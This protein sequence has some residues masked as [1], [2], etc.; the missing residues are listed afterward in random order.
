MQ[1]DKQQTL[2]SIFYVYTQY[3]IIVHNF[4]GFSVT[5]LFNLKNQQAILSF[6]KK[7][8]VLRMLKYFVGNLQQFCVI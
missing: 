7:L 2:V 8:L 4:E 3:K 1:Y 6:D 5:A